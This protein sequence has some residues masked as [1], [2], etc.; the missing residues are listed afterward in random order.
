MKSHT[1]KQ[2]RKM[3][4]RLPKQIQQRAIESYEL[5]KQDVYHPSLHFKRVHSTQPIYSVRISLGYRSVG[6]R[7]NDIMIWFWIGTHDAYDKLLLNF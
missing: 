5:F 1:T 7:E 6:I 3:F 2:F 4:E